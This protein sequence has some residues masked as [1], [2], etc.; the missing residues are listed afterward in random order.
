MKTL[1]LLLVCVLCLSVV[2]VAAD[3][4]AQAN[5]LLVEA[6][7]VIQAAEAEKAATE[8]LSLL[9]SALAKL[10]EIVESHPTTDLAVKLIT[11]QE[12]GNLSM[13]NL[14]TAIKAL[15]LEA[16]QATV[17]ARRGSCLEALDFSDPICLTAYA[18]EVEH[19]VPDESQRV[20]ALAKLAR[21]QADADDPA[22]A[23]QTLNKALAIA[24]DIVS[25]AGLLG[26]DVEKALTLV[27]N[28]T[29]HAYSG[30][31]QNALPGIASEFPNAVRNIRNLEHRNQLLVFGVM[32][33]ASSGSLPEVI[34][35]M[36]REHEDILTRVQL[37]A[38]AAVQ[39]ALLG[40]VGEALA[41]AETALS[42]AENARVS[43]GTDAYLAAGAVVLA[44]SGELGDEVR[45]AVGMIGESWARELAYMTIALAHA[46]GGNLREARSA[47]SEVPSVFFASEQGLA[48]VR[49]MHG[50]AGHLQEGVESEEL[51]QT[52]GALVGQIRVLASLAALQSGAAGKQPGGMIPARPDMPNLRSRAIRPFVLA[53]MEARNLQAASAIADA[54]PDA[55]I[56]KE[57]REEIA[58]LQQQV[59]LRAQAEGFLQ[60][61]SFQDALGAVKLVEDIAVRDSLLV[62]T[63]RGLLREGNF[64]D[65]QGASNLIENVSDR[66]LMLSHI[67]SGLLEKGNLEDALAVAKAMRILAVQGQPLVKAVQFQVRKGDFEGALAT[68]AAIQHGNSRDRAFLALVEARAAR[69]G[70]DTAVTLGIIKGIETAVI[71]DQALT[72]IFDRQLQD[73]SIESALATM[74]LMRTDRAREGAVNA[75]SPIQAQ[76]AIKQIQAGD[77]QGAQAT[78]KRIEDVQARDQVFARVAQGQV[79]AGDLQG[80]VST[81]NLMRDG[82]RRD[83]VRD[84]VIKVHMQDGDLESA[85]AVARLIEDGK[86]HDD[87]LDDIVQAQVKA[88][89]LRAAVATAA[90]M[91]VAGRRD[92]IRGA[93]VKIHLQAG[94]LENALT[95]AHLI[96]NRRTHDERLGDIVQAQVEAEDLQAAVSTAALMHD[97]GRR[98]SVRSVVVD[99]HLRSGDL[100]SALALARLI[101]DDHSRFSRIHQIANAQI[102]AGAL[103]IALTTAELIDEGRRD[104]VR[105]VVV[106]V[107]LRSGDLESALAL[108]Q[109]IGDDHSRLRRI[110]RIADA[111]LKAGNL[112]QGL[113][114]ADLMERHDWVDDIRVKAV[115][116]H[117]QSEDLVSALALAES[118]VDTDKRDNRYYYIAEAYLK[119]GELERALSTAELMQRQDWQDSIRDAAG[120]ATQ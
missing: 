13:A 86:A 20:E 110:H 83:S 28:G 56:G 54:I 85:V 45:A 40:H 5:R 66:D 39:Q 38:A 31:L 3:D 52:P 57:L 15:R 70:D 43:L 116:I 101:G 12:I 11:G 25:M 100:E 42:E 89:D 79:D 118:I 80:A 108:A 49:L 33:L 1:R 22:G 21:A 99:V 107:H 19:R 36:L 60:A 112:R 119:A 69:H 117:M 97:E 75:A 44:L 62:D 8:K 82:V 16:N 90:H 78:A 6:V 120:K 63:A 18:Q 30:D 24:E 114:A 17:E 73:R 81:A 105:S 50:L 94:D 9:Q 2:P 7:R 47:L 53:Q 115:G 14:E 104:S 71:H 59:D 58:R 67:A 51:A 29:V 103:E 48:G 27:I 92:S 64:K 55:G 76:A 77:L 46:R 10:N 98:D 111:Y 23:E 35:T 68:A 87:R 37:L 88:G 95:V 113:S 34:V 109:L 61:G 4:P 93:V 96:E 74:K 106:D 102:D 41:T 91:H 84:A 32:G 72:A 26:I 65:A